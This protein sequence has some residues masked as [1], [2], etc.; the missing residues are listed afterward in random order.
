MKHDDCQAIGI[1]SFAEHLDATASQADV[2][3]AVDRFNANPEIDAF[4]VQLPL[5]AG[6]NEEQVLLRVD[7]A[8]DVDGLH[9]PTWDG[10]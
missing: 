1:K 6:I 9:P 2:E 7:Y 8:K 3:A 4:L 5:P 10:S